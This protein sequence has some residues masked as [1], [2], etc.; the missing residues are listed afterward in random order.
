MSNIQYFFAK[1]TQEKFEL[2]E[3]VYK[4]TDSFILNTFGYVWESRGWWDKFPI[5]VYKINNVIA[6]IHA[7]TIDTKGQDIIK[8]YYIVT[9][10]SFRGRGIAKDLTMD[11]LNEY[12]NTNKKYFVNSEENSDGAKFYKKLF[13]NNYTVQSNDFNTCDLI[14]KS[15]IKDL[16]DQT[17]KNQ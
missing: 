14:F 4:N 5:Q 11:I 12:K 16:L 1:S 2:M 15:T 10:K 3:F 6:G 13:K 17:P 9:A 7:F 8:T